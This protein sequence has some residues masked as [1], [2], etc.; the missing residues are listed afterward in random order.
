MDFFK[1]KQLGNLIPSL[2]YGDLCLCEDFFVKHANACI[3]RTI[4]ENNPKEMKRLFNIL[5][6]IYEDGTNEVQS[7]IAVTV[8]GSVAI[9]L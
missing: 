7:L 2:R 5:C 1:V 8:L 4:R 9:I 6:E 3:E